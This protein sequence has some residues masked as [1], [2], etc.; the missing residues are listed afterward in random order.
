V[1]PTPAVSCFDLEDGCPGWFDDP[2]KASVYKCYYGVHDVGLTECNVYA[3]LFTPGRTEVGAPYS[4][5]STGTWSGGQ[6]SPTEGQDAMSRA[7]QDPETVRQC[8]MTTE[9]FNPI[10]WMLKGGQ[11][12]L[13]WAFVPRPLVIEAAAAGGGHAWDHKAPAVVAGMVGSIALAPSA[14]GCSRSVTLMGV[15]FNIIDACSGP[16]AAL[17][18]TSRLVTGCAFGFM[19]LLVLR[20]QVAG[21]LGARSD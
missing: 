12:L 18:T 5:P 8:D 17:A 16:M 1:S 13:E 15:S 19:V 3:G 10:G 14:S 2:S 20:R 7:V 11:C 9:G 4:D 21:M 6:N